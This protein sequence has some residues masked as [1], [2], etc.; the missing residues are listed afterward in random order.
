LCFSPFKK[1][2]A[3]NLVK[4]SGTVAFYAVSKIDFCPVLREKPSQRS[5]HRQP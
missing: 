1:C 5:Q 2:L 3:T 4:D